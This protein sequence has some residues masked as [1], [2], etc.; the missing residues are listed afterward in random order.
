MSDTPG[1]V[2]KT[3]ETIH[4]GRSVEAL[5]GL[6]GLRG[7]QIPYLI[8]TSEVPWHSTATNFSR[9]VVPY[10]FKLVEFMVRLVQAPTTNSGRFKAGTSTALALFFATTGTA[11]RIGTATTALTLRRLTTSSNFQSSAAA[12]GTSGMM[13]QLSTV[14]AAAGSY[15]VKGALVGI[16]VAVPR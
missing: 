15:A 16:F 5:P 3:E 7:D 1:L 12:A 14:R 8:T 13:V 11:N 4:S 2:G 9:R 10:N 6:Y